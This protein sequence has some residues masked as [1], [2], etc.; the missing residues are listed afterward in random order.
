MENNRALRNLLDLGQEPAQKIPSRITVSCA[1]EGSVHLLDCQ[2]A[3]CRGPEVELKDSPFIR[4]QVSVVTGLN[5]N[6]SLNS[7]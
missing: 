7:G 1:L 3:L 5:Y 2:R 6:F 4:A